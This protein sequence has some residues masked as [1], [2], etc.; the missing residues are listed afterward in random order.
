MIDTPLIVSKSGELEESNHNYPSQPITET[1]I[2]G[3][4]TLDE[5]GT[6]LYWN[7]AAEQITGV[8][9]S[10]AVG[11]NLWKKFRDIIPKELLKLEHY[12]QSQNEPGHFENYRGKM[13]A[14]FNVITYH[15][16][17]TISVSFKSSDLRYPEFSKNPT[18]QLQTLT[19]L[20][21][22]VI[23]IT[24]DCL[25]EWNLQNAEIFWIDDRHKRIFGYQVENALIPQLF[26]ENCIHPDDRVCVLKGLKKIIGSGT[27]NLW[28]ERYRFRKADGSY[29]YVHDRGHVIYNEQK[30]A[31]RIIGATR[32][33]TEQVL[34]EKK[35]TEER[36]TKQRQITD[37]VLTAQE[38]ERKAIGTELSENLN[39]MLAVI[40]WNIQIAITEKD[41]S[42]ECLKK[43]SDYLLHTM[44]DIRRIYKTLIVPD[45]H[46]IGLSGNVHNLLEEINKP[47]TLKITFITEGIDEKEDLS[48]K[49]QLDIYR[50]VQEQANNIVKHARAANATVYLY[51]LANEIILLI[52]DD[53]EGTDLQ[54]KKNGVG[55]INIKSRAELYG[56]IV[57]Q[58]SKPGEGHSLKVAFPFFANDK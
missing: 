43:S 29:A 17:N 51:R 52:T 7:R 4:F 38:N 15:C 1:L 39:Q 28:E 35:I 13:D 3:F 55:I 23:E 42:D 18:Q 27:I 46:A 11:S 49:L 44:H 54:D 19:Q 45:I 40:K 30:Q 56:G 10:E 9:A 48:E 47:S 37:A 24:N 16:G 20:Y 53:G 12:T 58:I 41:K 8:A 36:L 5:N 21:R 50:I 31:L 14:W 34:S 57:T 6:V 33:I 2:N 25:W 32:D 22:F 26:W